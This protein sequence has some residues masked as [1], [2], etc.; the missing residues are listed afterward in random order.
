MNLSIWRGFRE[1]GL[2]CRLPFTTT[3]ITI[4]AVL[5]LPGCVSIEKL[6]ENWERPIASPD[7]SSLSGTYADKGETPE[8]RSVS[9]AVVLATLLD[10]DRKLDRDAR[11]MLQDKL[12]Y[13]RNVAI[14]LSDP[15]ELQISVIG[16]SVLLDTNIAQWRVSKFTCRES[17]LSIGL[18]M[19]EG[20]DNGGAIRDVNLDLQRSSDHLLL[21]RHGSEAGFLLLVPAVGYSSHW[22]RFPAAVIP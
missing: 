14:N 18:S 13:A 2:I 15:R 22:F 8:G 12:R 6:P 16:E 21:N 5:L 20:A 11:R 4:V 7:C 17:V 3:S 10:V 1:V 9:L 19:T